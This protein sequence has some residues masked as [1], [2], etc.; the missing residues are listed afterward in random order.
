MRERQ[1]WNWM[2]EGTN[3]MYDKDMRATSMRLY[4]MVLNVIIKMLLMDCLCLIFHQ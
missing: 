2:R 1:L 4:N 3:K